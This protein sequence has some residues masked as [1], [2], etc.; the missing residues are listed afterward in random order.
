MMQHLER[1]GRLDLRPQA[2]QGWGPHVGAVCQSG[3][4]G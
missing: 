2:G 1:V 4:M 3:I